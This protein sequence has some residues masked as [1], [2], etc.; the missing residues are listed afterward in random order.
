MIHRGRDMADYFNKESQQMH[1][2]RDMPELHQNRRGTDMSNYFGE[3]Q[4]LRRGTD[5]Y[6]PRVQCDEQ[7]EQQLGKLED[8][9][10]RHTQKEEELRQTYFGKEARLESQQEQ[11][12][13]QLEQEQQ[14]ISDELFL[15][16]TPD[17]IK[18]K[19]LPE[20][21]EEYFDKIASLRSKHASDKHKLRETFLQ[22]MH[23]MVSTHQAEVS[24]HINEAGNI[25][26]KIKREHQQKEE[27]EERAFKW[28]GGKRKSKKRICSSKLKKR[29]CKSKRRQRK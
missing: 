20:K 14:V 29:K 17:N 16:D 12:I 10:A 23:T 3:S 6:A 4:Q 26:R 24:H 7:I 25:E 11:E 13:T 22:D 21:Y 1:R 8:L 28:G 27:E 2:G 19:N 15:S 9:L 18:L 5:M